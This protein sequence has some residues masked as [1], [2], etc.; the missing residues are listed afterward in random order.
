MSFYDKKRM[1]KKLDDSN[2]VWN[3]F[4]ELQSA[5][6]IGNMIKITS[7][8]G[9]ERI[10]SIKKYGLSANKVLEKAEA[11]IGKEVE[12]R[13]SQAT[14]AWSSDKWFSDIKEFE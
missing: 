1:Q 11:L 13:T 8:D 5:S 9:Q 12:V 14:K 4:G 3:Y 10:M 6:K 2:S 7:A